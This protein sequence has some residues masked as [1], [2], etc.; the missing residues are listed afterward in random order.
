MK[1]ELK[2]YLHLYLGC[3]CYYPPKENGEKGGYIKL[4][5]EMLKYAEQIKPI[6]RPLSDMTEKEKENIGG[7]DWTSVD[8]DWEYS[9]ETFLFLL[10][11]RFDIFGLIEAGFAVNATELNSVSSR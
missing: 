3:D 7:T 2:D 1:K 4:L 9:P 11:K 5:P 6:L 10:S 8:G